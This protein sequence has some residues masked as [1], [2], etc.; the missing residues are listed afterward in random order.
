MEETNEE[1]N[2]EEQKKLI[3]EIHEH[4][5]K[6]IALF[7]EGQ[8][9]HHAYQV[10]P[11]EQNL[12]DEVDNFL[13]KEREGIAE[14]H[15]ATELQNELFDLQRKDMTKT[16]QDLREMPEPILLTDKE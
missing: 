4:S 15:T 1:T 7:K 16:L 9:I 10:A 5:E 3:D 14:L 13:V 8:A 2:L 12:T 11:E 6:G